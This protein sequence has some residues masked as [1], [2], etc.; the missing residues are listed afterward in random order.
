MFFHLNLTLAIFKS[1]ENI[2]IVFLKS[3]LRTFIKY[4][5][6]IQ[7]KG[8]FNKGTMSRSL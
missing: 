6:P 4:W 1:K 2:K 5:E 7:F 3:V 8:K